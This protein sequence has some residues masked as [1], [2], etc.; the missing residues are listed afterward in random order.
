LE[1]PAPNPNGPLVGTILAFLLGLGFMLVADSILLAF[2][3]DLRSSRA[4]PLAVLL[5]LLVRSRFTTLYESYPRMMLRVGLLLLA[6][7]IGGGLLIRH[8]RSP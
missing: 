4:V 7:D 1:R 8:L 5:A 3:G 6:L 2:G